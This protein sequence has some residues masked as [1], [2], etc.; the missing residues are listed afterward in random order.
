MIRC[1][2]KVVGII[3]A[4]G[5]ALFAGVSGAQDK[6]IVLRVAD[7]LPSG[8]FLTDPLVKYW[9]N[10]V[11]KSTN[12]A[13][14]F[15]YYPSEQLGKAKD[16]LALTLSGVADVATIVP[17]YTSD[18]LPLTAVTE[19]PGGSEQSCTATSAFRRLATGGGILATQ[20]YAPLGYRVIFALVIPPQQIFSRRELKSVKSF[21]GMKLTTAGGAKELMLRKLKA[22]PIRMGVT[23][24]YESLSRGTIDG[25]ILAT[26]SILSYNLSGPAKYVTIG[27]N[28]GSTGVVGGISEARWKQLPESVQKA[29]LEAGEAAGNNMCEILDKMTGAD[30]EKLAQRGMTAM[31]FSPP[32]HQEIAAAATA[33]RA[34][35][36]ESLD[37]RGKPGT[38]VLKAFNSALSIGR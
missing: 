27:E 22:V 4:F 35:W 11:T 26:A 17:S 34:E 5:L 36:A 29:M 7:H 33:V 8:H 23:D 20:E 31:R 24:I 13:V 32:D 10:A 30:Y 21:E 38:E 15:E 6:K 16:L 37:K 14:Q 1:Y 12:G 9:M 3:M 25:G 2:G 18:K 28:F 19:L